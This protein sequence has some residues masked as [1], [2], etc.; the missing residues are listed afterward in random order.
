MFYSEKEGSLRFLDDNFEKDFYGFSTLTNVF[1]FTD[2]IKMNVF[3]ISKKRILVQF[4]NEYDNYFD[5]KNQYENF[6]NILSVDIR[7]KNI[8]IAE[9]NINGFECH[10]INLDS[11]FG[12][13]DGFIHY[14]L[15]PLEFKVFEIKF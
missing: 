15:Y 14:R 4:F 2:K 12:A 6:S 3:Y 13:N 9:C 5:G 11:K 8:K 10:E 1:I 7:K